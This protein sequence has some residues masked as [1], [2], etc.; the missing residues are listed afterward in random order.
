MYDVNAHKSTFPELERNMYWAFYVAS[1]GM[2]CKVICSVCLFIELCISSKW[3]KARKY[4]DM[5]RSAS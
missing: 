3:I 4:Q 2:G 5:D 1:V